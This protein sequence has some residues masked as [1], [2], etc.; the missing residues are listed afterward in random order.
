MNTPNANSGLVLV[1]GD[2]IC[3]HAYYRGNRPTA[4][5][6]ERPGFR[7]ARTGGGALLLK[8][9]IA[10]ALAGKQEWKVEFGLD[11]DF[12][13]LP[14]QYHAYCLWEPQVYDPEEKDSEKQIKVWRA[15]EPPLGYGHPDSE[16]KSETPVTHR[17]EAIRPRKKALETDPKVLVIDDAG[18]GFRHPSNRKCWPTQS[19]NEARTDL[20]WVVLKLTGSI[21]EGEFWKEIVDQYREKLI[22]IVSADQLR[23]NDI[24]ISRGQSWEA[25]VEDLTA[26]LKGN[27]LLKPL[28][29][30]R[31]LI[32]T[33][34]SDGAFWLDNKPD[35]KSSLLVFDA[36][37]GEGEWVQSQGRGTVFG[38]LSC[39]TA[40]IV[41]T[42]C[43]ESENPDLESALTAGL[44][45]ARE[46]RRMGHGRVLISQ[47][48]D[49]GSEKF[50]DNPKFGFPFAEIAV[51]IGKPKDKFVSAPIPQL[52]KDRGNW[53][54]LDEWQVHARTT[55][56][57]RP[58]FEAA[59]A[60]AVLGP[61]ALE[62]FP[63]AK[64]GGLQT[65]D[66]KEIESLRT[67]RKLI[68]AYGKEERPKTPLNL[69]VF[70]PPG[71]G[72]SFGVTQ[73][74]KA[75]LKLK[76]EDI[77]TFNL[78]QFSEANELIGA[79]HQVRDKVL[80]G[81]TPLVFW[82][83]F[84]SREYKWLQ[85]LLAPMQDGAFQD[86]QVTHLIG[87]CIFV[88]AG[89]TCFTYDTFGPL[90][91]RHFSNEELE[92]LRKAPD[93]LR[94]VEE[95]WQ[96]FVL[97]KGPD[98]KSRLVGYLNVLGP[99]P[100]QKW[101]EEDGRRRWKDDPT[102]FCYP[103]R[104][105]LFIRAQFKVKEGKRLSM[106]QGVLRAMLEVPIYKS[107]SR[108]LQFLCNHL[109]E[110]SSGTPRRSSLPGYELLDMHVEASKF[111]EL[112]EQDMSFAPIA[113]EL[114]SLMHEGY[115]LRIK[116]RVAKAHLDVPFDKLS[117]DM[118]LANID[119]ALRI[120]RILRLVNMHVEEG[121][122]VHIGDLHKERQLG[123]ES[124]RKLLADP[125]SLDRLAE[126]E[127]NGWM[128]ERMLNGW[129]YSRERDDAQRLHDCLIPY[130]QLSHDIQNFDR[131][132][133][134]GQPPPPGKP[135]EEQFGYVDIV[136]TAGLR[137]VM[138]NNEPKESKKR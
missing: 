1:T 76:D 133:I 8:D 110:N 115:R 92:Q 131:W 60:V 57:Q 38:F 35:S 52:L 116:G 103:I 32:V 22:V 10:A 15:V 53:M 5:S 86:G 120:P 33:F 121:L 117:E 34:Q 27:P 18:L 111:W 136:K 43:I 68:D 20:Q 93:Q 130:S 67:I 87:K 19:G 94:G 84:D 137:V 132:T 89:A 23:R 138:D 119:Q 63:V 30:A 122:P 31:H 98:F 113:K 12:E 51:R 37:R 100:R 47:R 74:A 126:A 105:A 66:R 129:R 64:F 59:M 135:D 25:T 62:R 124:I 42:L 102:D 109:R 123:E 96:D 28:L 11:E 39:F 79:F 58:H 16:S 3:D 29:E 82:D 112:C 14:P 7:Y 36:K 41:R 134:I 81:V 97:R 106:D 49:D 56:K 108:S 128:V 4:D 114:A 73:I 55:E 69:G 61:E 65:V 85:Y 46:L 95:V 80:S 90:S 71:A 88:F 72:K 99:N 44:N 13:S 104:R 127:H 118:Q 6:N 26:E 48:T 54:M 75:I 45:A 107:G 2:L 77:L 78:S 50:V 17:K 70:G 125:D 101:Y 9:L 91:L 40:A 24:R 21:G 83:E